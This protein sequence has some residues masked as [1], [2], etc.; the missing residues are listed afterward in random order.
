MRELGFSKMWLKLQQNTF[1]TFR[2][3]RKDRD[4]AVGETVK[5]VYHPRHKDRRV[6]GQARIILKEQRTFLGKPIDTPQISTEEAIADGFDSL[7][8]MLGWIAKTYGHIPVE[9]INK[10]T[11]QW[12][13]VQY[14]PK[15]T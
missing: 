14:D 7:S 6:I 1:T 9:P 3:P 10:L 13:E 2:F 15:Q 5:V 11:I 8:G 4:W 12:M